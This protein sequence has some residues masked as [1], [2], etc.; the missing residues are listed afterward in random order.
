M[1]ESLRVMRIGFLCR[2]PLC[3][4]ESPSVHGFDSC[5]RHIFLFLD[6][7][8]KNFFFSSFLPPHGQA[9]RAATKWHG[10]GCHDAPVLPL[11]RLDLIGRT[12]AHGRLQ[13]DGLVRGNAYAPRCGLLRPLLPFRPQQCW[14][15][16]KP[17]QFSFS[18]ISLAMLNAYLAPLPVILGPITARRA[19]GAAEQE[20]Q[21]LHYG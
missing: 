8:F 21:G 13:L 2:L 4:R 9:A 17:Q 14:P 19:S 7:F 18:Y 1:Q 3:R 20:L 15:R 10:R 5:A 16:G 12:R 6:F 11:T